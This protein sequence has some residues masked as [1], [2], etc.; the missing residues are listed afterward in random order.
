MHVAVVWIVIISITLAGQ[1]LK[2]PILFRVD[3]HRVVLVTR[4][5]DDHVDQTTVGRK[6]TRYDVVDQS[7]HRDNAYQFLAF[8]G[9][10]VI[11]DD[12]LGPLYGIVKKKT[13]PMGLKDVEYGVIVRVHLIDRRYF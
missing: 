2:H 8:F 11:V 10:T 12:D 4:V 1:F 3:N 7:L 9:R 6:D 5:L 13:R